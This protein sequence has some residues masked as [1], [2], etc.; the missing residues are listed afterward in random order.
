M[1]T[2]EKIV[3]DVLEIDPATQGE[4]SHTTHGEWTSIKQVQIMISLEDAYDV[5]F[6]GD[7]MASGTSV[8]RLREMLAGKGVAA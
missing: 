8:A 5:T 7:E 3:C 6:T 4:I 1:P 2:L